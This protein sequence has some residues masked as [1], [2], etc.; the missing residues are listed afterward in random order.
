MPLDAVVLF[1]VLGLAAGILKVRLPFPDG[2]YQS[3]T[4]FL[5]LAIGLKGGAARAEHVSPRIVWQSLM[6]G[7]VGILLPLLAF[8]LLRYAGGLDRIN[9]AAIAAHYGSV[10]V[11]T[12][13]VAV[14]VLDASGVAYEA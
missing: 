4:L 11:A 10:S 7:G 1:F 14:A 3:L 13:A 2:L 6:V 12:Y 8:P 9:A 5:L